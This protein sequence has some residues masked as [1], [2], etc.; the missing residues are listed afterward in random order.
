MGIQEAAEIDA[1]ARHP[2]GRIVKLV[3]EDELDWEAAELHCFM[4]QEKVETYVTFVETGQI[5]EQVEKSEPAPEVVLEL[6]LA[7]EPPPEAATF[8][9]RVATAVAALG[10]RFA[11]SVTDR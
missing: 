6:V 10:L 11:W 5:W 4:I 2:D 1:I 9:A 8:L 7:H 3:M